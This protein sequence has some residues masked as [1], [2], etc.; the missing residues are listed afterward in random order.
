LGLPLP[1]P[2]WGKAPSRAPLYTLVYAYGD[3]T[4]VLALPVKPGIA[5]ILSILVAATNPEKVHSYLDCPRLNGAYL[6]FE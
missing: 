6:I 5:R 3:T 1:Y 2:Q 4:G